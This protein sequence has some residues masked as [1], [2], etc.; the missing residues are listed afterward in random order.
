MTTPVVAQRTPSVGSSDRDVAEVEPIRTGL[1][2]PPDL[3]RAERGGLRTRWNRAFIQVAGSLVVGAV[4]A[5]TATYVVE[6][7]YRTTTTRL[8]TE[9]ALI[10]NTRRDIVTHSVNAET[11][12]TGNQ[13]AQETS[14]DATIRAELA[15]GIRQSY[16]TPGRALMQQA[17]A[18]W[19]S[20]VQ[21]LPIVT[22]STPT[23][24]I[25]IAGKATTTQ[26]PPVLRLLDE[27]GAASTTAAEADL[28]AIARFEWVAIA[29]W[30]AFFVIAAA[31]M[32]RLAR[33]LSHEVI[34]PLL[35]LRAYA[36]QLAAG[37]LGHRVELDRDDEVGD[38]AHSFNAMADAV[39]GVHR[40]LTHEATHDSLTGLA[41]RAAF[42][43]RVEAA[44]SRRPE[45][46]GTQAVLFVD[47]DDFKDVNDTLGHAAGDELLEIVAMRL[48]KVVRTGDFVA[49]LGGDE[50]ALLLESLPS[51]ADAMRLAERTVTSLAEPI[52]IYGREVN[53]G[54]SIGLAVLEPDS[55]LSSIMRQADIAMY[56]A[57]GRGKNRVESYDSTLHDVAVEHQTLK[58]DLALAADL[59]ELVLDYQPVLDLETSALV[60][61]EALVHWQHPTRGLL[62]LATFVEVAED[63]GAIIGI[64]TWVLK[65][66]VEDT[67]TWQRQFDRP[68]LWVSVNVSVRQLESPHFAMLVADILETSGLD[69][70]SLVVELTES[71]LASPADGAVEQ[72]E[73]LR[74]L[75]VRVALDDFGSGYSSIGYLR[76]L[77]VDILKIDRSFVSGAAGAGAPLLEAIVNLGKRLGMVVIPEGIEQ[78]DDLATVRALGCS[79]GQGFLL[80]RPVSPAEIT[81]RLTAA[82]PALLLATTGAVPAPRDHS[83]ARCARPGW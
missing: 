44:L 15:R 60:G 27:A 52:S 75:G 73:K 80:S 71:V 59:G 47:I 4:I 65:K 81:Q 28:R 79:I 70:R 37:D 19:V 2:T 36:N 16:S 39:A 7:R 53:V 77:P 82:T 32:V 76:H 46:G 74:D 51:A 67:V 38:L 18:G 55:D 50:F 21:S 34:G 66:A 48:L 25:V 14:L 13:Q 9:A 83:T 17:L 45:D 63:S 57:K 1:S 78:P 41:N 62:R 68:D 72:L 20:Y 58:V 49:R 5:G 31:L 24:V 42:H 56:S 54:A 3:P 33:R 69:P 43:T 26:V 23:S 6:S 61:I 8:D 29:A 22:T 40:T 30:I 10:S 11:V 64:G 12:K 35:Q